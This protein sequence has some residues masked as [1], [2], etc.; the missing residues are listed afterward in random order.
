MI[1]NKLYYQ[2]SSVLEKNPFFLK[3]D[4]QIEA[5]SPASQR[6]VVFIIY[7]HEPKY[8][9]EVN[10]PDSADNDGEYT[11]NGKMSPGNIASKEIFSIK[12]ET[13][14]LCAI[15]AWVNCVWEELS[16]QPFLKTAKRI[17]DQIE[18]VYTKYSSPQNEYFTREETDT[19]RV[20]LE[21]LEYDFREELQV[22]L[23]DKKFEE[24][25]RIDRLTREMENLRMTL[26]SLKKSSWMNVFFSTTYNLLG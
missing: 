10:I 20:H 15:T 26:S 14:L 6:T 3:A 23:K 11:F 22:E 16:T 8:E 25:K 18:E 17:E 13:N 9:F 7:K 19:L 2:I 24:R 4:F 5:Q 12:G 21:K 1:R